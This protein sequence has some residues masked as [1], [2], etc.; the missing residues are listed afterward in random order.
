MVSVIT[1]TTTLVATASMRARG[2]V[3]IKSPCTK[4]RARNR[5]YMDTRSR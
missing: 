3:R 5:M 4:M 1:K 2:F